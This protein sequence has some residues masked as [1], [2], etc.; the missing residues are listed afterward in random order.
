MT[1]IG[2]WIAA[3]CDESAVEIYDSVTGALRLSLRPTDQVHTIKGSS[4]GSMLFCVHGGPSISVWDIQTG[5]LIHTLTLDGVEEF[6]ICL[7]GRYVACGLLDGSIKIGGVLSKMESAAFGTGSP[8]THLC[9]L[10]SGKQ[11]VVARKV[12]VQVW[13]VVA[14]QVLHSFTNQGQICGV[15]HAQKLHKF[16]TVATSEAESIVTV[17][18]SQTGTSFTNQARQWISCF[19]FS[20][21]TNELVCGGIAPG[22][23]LFSIQARDWRQ[24]N[25]PATITSISTLSNGT[26][27]AGDTG[28]SIQLLSLDEGYSPPQQ[29]TVSVLAVYTLDQGNIIATTTSSRDRITL[30]E[31]STLSPLFTIPTPGTRD[32]IPIDNHAILC[33]SLQHR[34]AIH[35]FETDNKTSLVLWRFGSE[36]P[37]WTRNITISGYPEVGGISPGGSRVVVLCGDGHE[38]HVYIWDVRSGKLQAHRVEATT[39]PH[40]QFLGVEFESEERIYSRHEAY[41]ILH[42]LPPLI[43]DDIPDMEESSNSEDSHHDLPLLIVDDISD[44]EESSDSED[45]HH[46]L[47][48]AVVHFEKLDLSGQSGESYNVNSTREWVIRSSKRICWIPPGY[49]GSGDNSHFWAGH[50]LVMAGHDGVLRSFTFRAPQH[51]G[52][53]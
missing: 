45:S 43:V 32:T 10:E 22:L 28:F 13:D 4:D 23:E 40:T 34:I 14:R 11:L 6:A 49:I 7:E 38:I 2:H 20:Q 46:D 19:A 25:H 24:F 48:V 44:M 21:I 42:V 51:F 50:T 36:Y 35:R 8:V 12:S 33:A 41:R 15:L 9:W 3:V 31:S 27:A 29:A 39:H 17:V 26:V 53:I 16:I 18:D 47:T 37:E 1:T 52:D 30:L 5:G